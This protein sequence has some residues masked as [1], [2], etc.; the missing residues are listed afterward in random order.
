MPDITFHTEAQYQIHMQGQ[1]QA[2]PRITG[3]SH[4]CAWSPVSPLPRR[5]SLLFLQ[6][7]Y[8]AH[9]IQ[10]VGHLLLLQITCIT[11]NRGKFF[12]VLMYASLFS[13]FVDWFFPAFLG[14][15]HLHCW[16]TYQ[17]C[18]RLTNTIQKQ[19]LP[20]SPPIFLKGLV[21]READ[22]GFHTSE[23]NLQY[24]YGFISPFFTVVVKM[25]KEQALALLAVGPQ[26]I[27]AFVS[28]M[29]VGH[30]QTSTYIDVWPHTASHP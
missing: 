1:N 3:S 30:T 18:L 23:D 6:V 15:Y 26:N 7:L 17:G 25:Y 9:T 29:A 5:R 12:L 16:P 20:Q 14:A 21:P 4:W 24:I 19:L 2:F 27:S 22:S 11:Q 13:R 8:Q 28:M 10:S